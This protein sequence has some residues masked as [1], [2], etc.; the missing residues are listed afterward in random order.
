[1]SVVDIIIFL[2]AIVSLINGYTRDNIR[3][4]G[5]RVGQTGLRRYSKYRES[6]TMYSS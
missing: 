6:E 4:C 3:R 2:K 5:K 1:M